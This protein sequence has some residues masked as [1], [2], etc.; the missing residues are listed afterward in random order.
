MRK[1]QSGWLAGGIT[2]E[3]PLILTKR[4]SASTHFLLGEKARQIGGGNPPNDWLLKGKQW[5]LYSLLLSRGHGD[6]HPGHRHLR[7]RD[8]RPRDSSAR[9]HKQWGGRRTGEYLL[10]QQKRLIYSKF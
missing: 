8:V 1:C 7:L 5:Q 10:S 6:P 3:F 9:A 2:S 4:S